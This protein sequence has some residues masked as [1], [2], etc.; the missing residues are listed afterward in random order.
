MFAARMLHEHQGILDEV[1]LKCGCCIHNGGHIFSLFWLL[2]I[3]N[4]LDSLPIFTST[5]HKIITF[6]NI[7]DILKIPFINNFGNVIW[8]F[9]QTDRT[10]WN[11][12]PQIQWKGKYQAPEPLLLPAFSPVTCWVNTVKSIPSLH[13]CSTCMALASKTTSLKLETKNEYF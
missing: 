9:I 11:V 4:M 6:Y 5:L 2:A 1:N 12:S 8:S 10:K 3:N 7:P 13:C